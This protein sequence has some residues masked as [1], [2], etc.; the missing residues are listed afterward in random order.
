M[1]PVGPRV[2][3][4]EDN[5]LVA[6]AF[7][8]LIENYAAVE[9]VADAAAAR[10]ALEAG[11]FTAV[12]LDIRLP[13]GSGLDVLAYARARGYD[14]PA[15][16]YS[17]NHEPSDVNRAFSLHAE[18]LVKPAASEALVSFVKRA[19]ER[20]SARAWMESWAARH[21]LTPAERTILV[22]AAEGQTR[23]EIDAQH[24]NA[25]TAKTHVHNL[26]A[27]TG[28]SSLLAAVTRALRERAS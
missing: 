9:L 5:D 4:V 23:S 7:E 17:G 10:K 27:K 3:V 2:L 14:G 19:L 15:L 11:E 1:S 24:A 22:A 8:M 26:L 20:R 21:Q 12:V 18:Y 25:V 6:R 13:D 16:I 28:D